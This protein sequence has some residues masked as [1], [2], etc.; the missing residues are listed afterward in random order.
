VTNELASLVVTTLLLAANKDLLTRPQASIYRQH[1]LPKAQL[2]EVAPA[3]HQGFLERHDDV[4]QA[5]EN[6][7][8]RV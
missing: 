2:V 3:G 5:A 7:I 8:K 4:N 1:Q 6:F